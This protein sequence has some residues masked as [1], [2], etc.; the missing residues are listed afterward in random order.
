MQRRLVQ[1]ALGICLAVGSGLGM[2]CSNAGNNESSSAGAP[3]SK[4]EMMVTGAS[5]S[6]AMAKATS[7]HLT[8]KSGSTEMSMDV[9]CPDKIRTVMKTGA[10]TAESVRVGDAMYVKAGA[11]WMKVPASAQQPAVCGGQSGFGGGATPRAATFDPNVKMTKKGADSVNGESCTV[12]EETS[13]DAKGVQHTFSICVGGD[14]LPRR[15]IA[16]DA[17]MTYS[18]WNKPVTIEAPTM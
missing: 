5:L 11:K 4:A 10:M 17:V 1:S 14:N 15:V 18:D 16:G 3:A 13:T 8:M 9:S 7:W 2:G 6:S 12:W